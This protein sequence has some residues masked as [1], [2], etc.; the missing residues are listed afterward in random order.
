M[1]VW[2]VETIGLLAP[3]IDCALRLHCLSFVLFYEEGLTPSLHAELRAPM[4][5]LHFLCLIPTLI[6]RIQWISS[7]LATSV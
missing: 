2:G 4:V 6:Y 1:R 5:G 3:E 7:V